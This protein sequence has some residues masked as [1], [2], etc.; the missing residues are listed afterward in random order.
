MNKPLPILF[1]FLFISLTSLAQVAVTFNVDCSQAPGFNPAI[2]EIYMSGANQ[3]G[4]HGF[5]LLPVW[6]MP[7]N[8]V[9][10]RMADP[11]NDGVYTITI[12]KIVPDV[13]AYKYYLV[14]NGTPTWDI[15]EWSGEPN[16]LITVGITNITVNNTWAQLAD[17]S[18]IA[19]VINEVMASNST[20]VS[21]E[22]GDYEDWIEIFNKGT[23]TVNLAGFGLTDNRTDLFKWEFPA[24][25]IAPGQ[26]LIVWTSDKDRKESVD[27]LHT[28]F[29]I[30]AEGEPIILTTSDSLFI[31]SIGAVAHRTDVSY[32]RLPD[33]TEEW[34]YLTTPTPGN[35]NTGPGF[36]LLLEPVTFSHPD[37]FYASTFNLTI[38][39]PTPGATIRYTLDGSEPT[40]SSTL[41]QNPISISSRAGEANTISMIPTNNSTEPGPPYY[42]GWQAP[43]GEVFKMNVV[44]ARAFHNDA[45]AGDVITY[46]YLVDPKGQDRYSLPVFSLTTHP[47]NLFNPEI[48]IYVAGNNDNYFQ[49]GWERPANLIF[50]ENDGLMAFKE[51][52]GIQLNGN[53]TRSRPRKAIRVMAKAEYGSSWINYKLFPNKEIER[54]KRF[55]LRGSGNDWDF[56]IFRDGLFQYLAKDLHLETQYYRPSILFIN[57]EYWGIHNIRDKYDQRFILT[58]YGIEENEMTILSDNSVFRWGVEAGKAHYTSMKNFVSNNSMQNTA[59]Y[60]QLKERIDIESFIDFQLTHIFVKNTDWPGN[61]ALY[62]RYLR[63]DFAPGEGVRD[64]RWRWMMLDTDFG[65]DLPFFYV[66]GLDDGAAHNTLDFATDPSG[67]SWPNPSWATLMLRKMLENS[68]FRIQFINRYCDLLNTTFSTTHV[69]STIDSIS[70][71]LAP[72]M[73]EHINRWRR[74]T[75]VSE[76]NNN[77]QKLKNFAIERPSYQLQHMKQ[78]FGLG[79]A[80][81]LSVNVSNQAHGFVRVNTIDIKSSTMGVKSNPY[82]WSGTYFTGVPMV[83]E[84]IPQQGYVF[85]HWSGGATG[86]S[87]TLALNMTANTQLT[88]HFV[89]SQ[90]QLI[91]YWFFGTDVPNDT[92]LE[93]IAPTFSQLTNA[94]VDFASALSGYPFTSAHPSWRKASMERRNSPSP[95]NYQPQGN[96]K[97]PFAET[98]MRAIQVRQPFTGDGGE[99][100]LYFSTPTLGFKEITFRFA[101]KDE[102]AANALLID[103]SVAETENWITDGITSTTLSLSSDYQSYTVDFLNVPSASN[104]SNFKI[105]IRFDG[106][107]LSVDEGKMV[108]FNNFSITGYDLS[109]GVSDYTDNSGKITVFPNPANDVISISGILGIREISLYDVTGRFILS[110]TEPEIN[111]SALK[112][113]LYIIKVTDLRGN[114]LTGKVMKR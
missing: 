5:G 17:N 64:G 56:A 13:Y 87:K 97:I 113:G 68:E 44:R 59:N 114:M 24:V 109:S 107:N 73:A 66:P 61:N 16:R 19:L 47:E 25:N 21:D 60:N 105:R 89:Q 32:G 102:G 2:H 26:Y 6:P 80:A 86:T 79:N 53:T 27:A 28:N 110:S 112:T 48:G 103:Y 1:T 29:K 96:N 81:T 72:E 31:D 46:S 83:L 33:G 82:P 50:F 90:E 14:E 84:A 95:I 12:S 65:F 77:V 9:G 18:E 45:P 88:A 11:E 15:G 30:S 71:L 108:T 70:G 36:P 4:T 54:F 23:N 51:N 63:D 42:E 101:A 58:K 92:P 10:F 37:G 8:E 39:S 69:V 94:S 7:G 91:H 85:S 111:V 34:L 104:N 76:W 20:I 78:K 40:Q 67:P 62:W 38:T 100:T 43:S 55:I 35:E 75:S 74:P 93:T 106:T 99:N 41:Y 22:D 57:G 49:D 52:I 98:N 3:S